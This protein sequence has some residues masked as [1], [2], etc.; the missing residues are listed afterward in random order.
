[1]DLKHFHLLFMAVAIISS[2]GIGI[3]SFSVSGTESS[4]LYLWLGVFFSGLGLVLV[5]YTILFVR[6]MKREGLL[7]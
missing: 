3:W 2:L 5:F 1:M 6:K 7:Q 4:S